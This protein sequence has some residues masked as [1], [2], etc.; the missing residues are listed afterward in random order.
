MYLEFYHL[1]RNPFSITPDP[2]FLFLSQSHQDALQILTHGIEERDG[3][4][5]LLGEAGSGKTTVLN[6]YLASVNPQQLKAIYIFGPHLSIKDILAL[7]CREFDLDGSSEYLVEVVNHIHTALVEEEKQGN[8]V[9]L[10]IDDAQNLS[11]DTLENLRMFAN[12]LENEVRRLV[13]V[14]LIGHEEFRRK[15]HLPE[16]HQL[17][18]RL[19][20]CAMLSPL[21]R[22]ESLDYI[23]HRLAKAAVTDEPVFTARAV[24]TI[25]R[26]AGG[27]PFHLNLLCREA[28]IAG[29]AYKEKPIS[30]WTVREVIRESRQT[31]SFPSPSIFRRYWGW[32]SAT[33]GMLLVGGLFWMSP[34]KNLLLSQVA[35]L[36]PPRLSQWFSGDSPPQYDA[37]RQAESEERRV[38]AVPT[39]PDH[40]EAVPLPSTEQ[41]AEVTQ[42]VATLMQEFFPTGGDFRLRVWPEKGINTVYT[43]GEKLLVHVLPEVG[44]YVQVDYYQVDG[45]VVHLLPNPLDHNFVSGGTTLTL[46]EAKS[47]YYFTISPPFG[48]EL[49][50]VIASRQPLENNRTLP[51]IEPAMAYLDRLAKQLEAYKTRGKVAGVH[52]LIPTAKR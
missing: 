35:A 20:T 11:V 19:K 47:S 2:E 5:A 31:H 16:L 3:F 29:F 49:L 7:F 18:L 22:K 12:L 48:H 15:L 52:V 50:T 13:Q 32:A 17:K 43:E 51:R 10:I 21:T 33:G 14:V 6:A 37:Q 27:V 28:L 36:E 46:G 25:V 8:R 41:R 4:I 24:R 44:A 1:E 34:Y 40:A 39:Q 30:T 42:R 23:Y 9:V 45:T 26:Y 38:A